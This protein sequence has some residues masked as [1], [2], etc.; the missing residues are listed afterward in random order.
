MDSFRGHCGQMGSQEDCVYRLRPEVYPV[1]MP[2]NYA[3]A[4]FLQTFE[5]LGENQ[6]CG[7]RTG[8][9][10]TGLYKHRKELEA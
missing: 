9:I 6:Q 10:Q 8:P 3:F 2:L 5:P 1:T 7:F 4:V